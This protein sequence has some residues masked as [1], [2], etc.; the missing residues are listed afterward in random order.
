MLWP[1]CTAPTWP[2]MLQVAVLLYL[3]NCNMGWS[4]EP[5]GEPAINGASDRA[6]FLWEDCSSGETHVR[7]TAGTGYARYTGSVSANLALESVS[8]FSIEATDNVDFTTDPKNIDFN[9]Q[10]S[11][12]WLDGFEFS[13]PA[14]ANICFRIDSP[15]NAAVFVGPNR[16]SAPLEFNPATL[17]ACG[18]GGL[19][20]LSVSDAS[21]P[22]GAGSAQTY[23]TLSEES[24]QTITVNY[25]ATDVS[26]TQS[27]DYI[28]TPGLLTFLPGMVS[29][30]ISATIIDDSQ[31]EG[32]EVFRITLDTPVNADLFDPTGDVTIVD[33]EI[34]PCGAPDYDP[35]ASSSVY[36][37]KDC[38]TGKWQVRY[39]AGGGYAVY[40]GMVTATQPFTSVAPYSVEANDTFEIGNPAVIDYRLQISPPYQDGMTFAVPASASLCFDL[41]APSPASVLL[42]AAQTPIAVPF[43]MD[44]LGSCGTAQ[45]AIYINDVSVNEDAGVALFDVTIS[46][47]SA[48][49]ITVD[50]QTADGS[51]TAP[52]DYTAKTARSSSTPVRQASKSRSI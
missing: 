47:I 28:L 5:C 52:N 23:V 45:P 7:F 1:V 8:L 15:G 37:W 31:S 11:P 14:G 39:T 29:Q 24:S 9:V 21:T 33:D 2:G 12:P 18:G 4:A 41:Q 32:N 10:L 44:T 26:A 36:V 17:G 43:D 27:E 6:V 34:S 3:A 30:P 20:G 13:Y 46:P 50:Y 25:S 49:L 40:R 19:P 16:V 38:T 42:G 22:E 35:A 51:A 48:Q